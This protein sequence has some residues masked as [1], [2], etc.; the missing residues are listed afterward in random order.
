VPP[1]DNDEPAQRDLEVIDRSPITPEH[2]DLDAAESDYY[3]SLVGELAAQNQELAAEVDRLQG[4]NTFESV[5]ARMAAPYADKVFWFLVW[6]CVFVGVIVL[7]SGFS[8]FGFKISDAVMCVIAG[9]TAVSAIG[10]VGFVVNGLFG[11]KP[12]EN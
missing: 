9:S 2:Q 3:I 1:P 8:P 10:L 12:K 4:L 11:S 5:R 7:F 6:Y